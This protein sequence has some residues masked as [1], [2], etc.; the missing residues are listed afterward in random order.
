MSFQCVGKMTKEGPRSKIEEEKAGGPERT[1]RARFLAKKSTGKL[2]L[3]WQHIFIK[4]L[5]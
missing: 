2:E 3:R 5:L 4:S 1:V